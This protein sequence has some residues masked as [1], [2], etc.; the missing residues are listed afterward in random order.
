MDE[1]WELDMQESWQ[2]EVN[3]I[4][5]SGPDIADEFGSDGIS[6]KRDESVALIRFLAKML[7]EFRGSLIESGFSDEMADSMSAMLMT[8]FIIPDPPVEESRKEG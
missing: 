7:S 4:M 1:S 2:Q 8:R 5:D 6:K 3:E